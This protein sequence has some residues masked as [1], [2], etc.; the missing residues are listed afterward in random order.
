MSDL[1]KQ[2]G[3]LT[4]A[5]FLRFFVKTLIGIALARILSPADYGS[6]RQLFL[7][8]ATF[9]TLLLLG[10]PQSMLYFLPKAGCDQEQKRIITRTVNVISILALI[11]TI[12]ILITKA[13]IAR[14]FNNP[15]L[16]SLLVV[17]SIYPLFM[18][19][20][21]IYSSIML[22]LKEPFQAARFTL[23]AIAVDFVLILGTALISRSLLAITAAVVVSALLQWLYA[24]IR[25]Q[26]YHAGWNLD[27][28]RGFRSQLSY[29]L[30][31]GLSSVVGMLSVQL[32]KLMISGFFT[33]Q[34]FAVFAVGAMELPLIGI[35]ANSVN[36]VLLPN[37]SATDKPQMGDIYS[38]AVRK[39]ALVIFPLT[40]IFFILAREIMVFLY[41]LP[42]ADAALYFRIYLIILPLRIATYSIL[43]QA[44]GKTRIIMINS[45]VFLLLNLILNYILIKT[46]G[47][48]GA[49]LATVIVTWISVIV[50]LIQ[51]KL[52]LKLHLRSL[53][54]IGK[55]ARTALAAMLAAL[56]CILVLVYIP[57]LLLRMILVG[58][59]YFAGY[60]LAGRF[61]GAILP[62][63]I[64]L[65]LDVLKD[66][67][68][69]LP[70]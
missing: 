35:L 13:E 24:N 19:V 53:F 40:V 62:Y 33:P 57:Q 12:L 59:L 69:K 15:A 36:S 22:G 30:P 39:N 48:K 54:P 63:D 3:L 2:A 46:L 56:P 17:Y 6:Y 51:I 47:M 52:I 60:Y 45:T 38:G 27:N 37:L 29:C 50:Y 14:R 25:L 58:L 28:L 10:I 7:I 70:L 44:M 67:K 16:N 43:F 49:A 11:L 1:S 18:F 41:G 68:R 66:I 65:A 9:S 32:D 64:N 61:S 34:Q 31:L 23:F 55:I 5:D 4:S 26:R 8:Y 20:T 21:Q 42:Y